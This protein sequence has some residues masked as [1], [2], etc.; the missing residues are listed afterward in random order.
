MRASLDNADD[1]LRAGMAFSI[2]MRFAGETF[3][4]VDP[5][6]IQWSAEGA[7]V[8]TGAD[9]RAMQVPV[10]IVQRNNDFVLVDADLE[11]GT[12]VVTEGVQLLRPGVAMRFENAAPEATVEEAPAQRGEAGGAP[13]RRGRPEAVAPR[14]DK[15][16]TA[17]GFT[18]LFVRRPIMGLVLNSLIVI[19]GLA[20]VLGVE[21]RELPDV[22]RPVI[23]VNTDYDGA[24][25]E[26]IDREVTGIIEGAMGRI[27]GVSDI[28]SRSS[29]GRSRVT[30]EFTDATDL[31]VAAADAR[32]SIGRILNQLPDD[33]DEPRIVKADANAEAVIRIGVT[34]RTM[35]VEALTELVET[36]ISD[37][38]IAAPGVADLQIY[39]GR[40]PIFRVDVDQ[41]A[42]A[43]RGLTI[44]DVRDALADVAF[45]SPAG[46]L[47]ASNQSLVVRTIATVNT[48][49]AFGALM[50][51][52]DTRLSD[53]ATVTLGPRTGTSVL[54][55]NG[56][57]GLGIGVL[58]QARSNTLEI[59][60][61]IRALVAELDAPCPRTSRSSS[62][63]TTRSSSPAPST[64]CCARWCSR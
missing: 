49:E 22:D 8:W 21:V 36:T 31:D 56:Q 40:E 13:P 38:L 39:G 32:D 9:G 50:L 17:A 57:A 30:V 53:V 58:R 46:A 3:P 55:S 26:T 35:P 41:L 60:R 12:L 5:L 2:A 6:A 64:R 27:S 48:P 11:P 10:R 59:S 18:A 61:D 34:S 7:Y 23:T 1:L 28:S 33:A 54:R 51:N 25:P 42:L 16:D 47:S 63:A 29:F 20:A 45:D 4:A 44:A 62:P 19:A 14:T 43:S 15:G 52:R 24:A 37:R